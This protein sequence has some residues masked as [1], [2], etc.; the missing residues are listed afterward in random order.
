MCILVGQPLFFK[1]TL[2]P[3]PHADPPI[4]SSQSHSHMDEES[5]ECYSCNI[6]TS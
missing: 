2:A 1:L 5:Y 4:V 6:M 3:Q